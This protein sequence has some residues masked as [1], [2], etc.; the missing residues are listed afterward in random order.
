MAL[1]IALAVGLGLAWPA[2]LMAQDADPTT[3]A[4]A[5]VGSYEVAPVH[6]LGVPAISVASPVVNR[7][8]N[9]PEATERAAVIEGNLSLLYKPRQLCNL[10]ET[11]AEQLLEGLVLGGPNNQRLCSGDPWAVLGQPD[12]LRLEVAN[13]SDGTIQLQARLRGR[14]EPLPLLTVTDAD[15]QLHGLS[16]EQLAGR[17]RQLLQ[18]RLRHA[19]FTEQPSQV[20]LRLKVTLLL[21]LLLLGTASA[22]LWLWGKLRRRLRNRQKAAR[23]SQELQSSRVQLLQG[24]IRLLFLAVLVQLVVM[25]GLAVAAVPGRIPLAIAVLLQPLSILFKVLALGMAVAALRLLVVF[26]LR[27]WVSNLAV[28]MAERAR[29]EQRYHNLLQASHR[30]I[31]LSFF[32]VLAVLVLIDIPGVRELTVGAWL[33]G[34]ALLGGLAIAFQGLL[35]DVVAGLVALLDD[36]YAVG[37]VVEINTISGEV[38][39]VGILVT[40]LRTADQRVVVIAN[41]ASQ[42]LVNHTKIRSGVEVVIPLSP[43]HTRLEEAMAVLD[44]ECAAFA[45]DPLWSPSLLQAP[46]VRGVKSVTPLAVE[47]SVVLTTRTGEQWAAERALLRRLVVRL[48]EAGIPLACQ[49][50]AAESSS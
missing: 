19:R 9:G 6:I 26:V 40:E 11:I 22:S 35:R 41:S 49:S 34:G 7:E 48:Q 4:S 43:Q 36:H 13:R 50:A 17:W 1:G 32:A 5:P 18:R 15:A 47:L 39:D 2:A 44:A 3:A 25:V 21:E 12:D 38:V 30:L 23:D 33:A 46:W 37:D 20:G 42:Q 16:R 45:R 27:Q 10:G 14:P 24:L 28:P 29:R 31:D 8:A